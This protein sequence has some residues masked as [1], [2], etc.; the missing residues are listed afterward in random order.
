[1]WGGPRGPHQ[2]RVNTFSS[3]SIN[4]P[5][6][7]P[8]QSLDQ[9]IGSIPR[10]TKA[11]PNPSKVSGNYHLRPSFQNEAEWL[12]GKQREEDHPDSSGRYCK[13]RVQDEGPKHL[14]RGEWVR[15][16]PCGS[17]HIKQIDC[18]VS[19]FIEFNISP[20]LIGQGFQRAIRCSN[21]IF[22]LTRLASMIFNSSLALSV[23]HSNMSQSGSNLNMVSHN[24][25]NSSGRR[26]RRVEGAHHHRWV[27]DI[28]RN[29]LVTVHEEFVSRL[30]FSV[31]KR[32]RSF[33]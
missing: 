24:L 14:R 22:S 21:L 17:K 20:N 29:G 23:S 4:E 10:G 12:G 33:M 3:I 2:A 26:P 1:M 9:F 13:W 32:M 5:C 31:N 7:E 25:C 30:T 8:F 11:K 16:I 27:P 15:R 19:P 18:R 28:F 6:R